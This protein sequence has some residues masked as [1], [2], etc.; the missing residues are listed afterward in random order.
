MKKLHG[1][2]PC[3]VAFALAG[4]LALLTPPA[5]APRPALTALS[6]EEFWALSDTLGEPPGEFTHSENLVSNEIQFVHTVRTLRPTGGVYIGV[7]PEQNFSYIARLRPAMAFIV[8]IRQENRSLHLMYKALFE[9]SADRAD[10]VFRLFSRERPPEAEPAAS[11]ETLFRH[12]A[13]ARPSSALRD[14]TARLVR[15]KLVEHHRL[16]LTAADLG[17][18]QHAIDTFYAEGPEVDYYGRSRPVGP[19][20][21]PSYRVLMTGTDIDG[22]S[23]SYLATDESFAF[24]KDLQSRNAVVPLVGDFGGPTTIR[25]V[26]GYLGQHEA[27][28]TAFYGSN[29]EVYLTKQ[30]LSAFCANLAALP[31]DPRAYFIDAKGVRMLAAKLDRCLPAPP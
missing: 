5:C 14:A 9:L 10:F 28:V 19:V 18:I 15:D 30:R 8:D 27:V 12:L 25:R 16:P 17:W 2:I 6:D 1:R 23:R 20:A 26:A 31:R 13:T 22:E 21:S 29:V 11:I 24:V 4:L 3:L 7:G